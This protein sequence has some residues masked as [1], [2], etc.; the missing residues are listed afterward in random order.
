MRQTTAFLFPFRNCWFISPFVPDMA[1]SRIIV[2]IFDVECLGYIIYYLYFD[3][4]S[5]RKFVLSISDNATKNHIQ[6]Q[7]C[8]C[9]ALTIAL[10]AIKVGISAFRI[11]QVWH[12]QYA[13]E[14]RGVKIQ[15]WIILVSITWDKKSKHDEEWKTWAIQQWAKNSG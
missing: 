6:H 10:R 3:L 12:V 9:I 2:F 4:C 7:P 8:P 14:L 1:W 13:W 15:F 5:T 11:V